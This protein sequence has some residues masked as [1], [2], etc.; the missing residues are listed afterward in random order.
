MSSF[1][2]GGEGE[3]SKTK[4]L[5]SG[6]G[7]A[8]RNICVYQWCGG[9]YPLSQLKHVSPSIFT[10]RFK[11]DEGPAFRSRTGSQPILQCLLSCRRRG[12][13]SD[14]LSVNWYS[15]LQIFSWIKHGQSDQ[16]FT[17]IKSLNN[18]WNNRNFEP[19]ILSYTLSILQPRWCHC[20]FSYQVKSNVPMI[21]LYMS[22]ALQQLPD[23]TLCDNKRVPEW[24]NKCGH[25]QT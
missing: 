18:Y 24:N 22:Q 4:H 8:F 5:I 17:A 20:P 23:S 14:R 13:R 16:I 15:D 9:V 12:A 2:L 10:P 1:Y 7:N 21:K 11:S 3:K 25:T 6:G 19:W